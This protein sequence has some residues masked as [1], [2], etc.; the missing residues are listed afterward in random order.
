[1]TEE[2]L[3]E[4]KNK[5]TDIQEEMTALDIDDYDED[6]LHDDFDANDDAIDNLMDA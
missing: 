3:E 1:M 6:D 4:Q 2:N 5:E